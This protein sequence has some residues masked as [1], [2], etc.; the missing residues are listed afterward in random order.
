MNSFEQ[1]NQWIHNCQN[2]IAITGAGF[3]TESGIPDFRGNE[4]VYKDT[5]SYIK[6]LLLCPHGRFL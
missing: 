2:I 5:K 6:G 4:G 3:S 1:L